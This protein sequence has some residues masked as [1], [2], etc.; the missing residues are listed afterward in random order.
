[1]SELKA[2]IVLAEGF[3]EME[4]IAPIDLLRRAGVN[5]TVASIT[6]SLIVAGRNDIVIKADCL[7]EEVSDKSYDLVVLPGGPGH[8]TLRENEELLKFLRKQHRAARLIGAICAAPVVLKS[9]GILG[10]SK[11]TC[12]VSVEQELPNR[13]TD[14]PVVQDQNIITSQGAGTSTRFAL[15]LVQAL[16]SKEKADTIARSIAFDRS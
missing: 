6:S 4:A 5:V 13:I 15:A 10:N 1:M 8:T 12:H 11:H 16:C 14:K 7:F 9:A 2:I 3:E